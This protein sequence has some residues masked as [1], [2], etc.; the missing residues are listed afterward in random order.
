MSAG[1]LMTAGNSRFL[2]LAL[3]FSESFRSLHRLGELRRL[4][5]APQASGAKLGQKG[6]LW[7]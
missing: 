1:V 6:T 4:A 5:P 7:L 3:P 2:S